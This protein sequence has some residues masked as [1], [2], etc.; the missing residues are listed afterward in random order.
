MEY[1]N[2]TVNFDDDKPTELHE[3]IS[4]LNGIKLQM[5]KEMKVDEEYDGMSLTDLILDVSKFKENNKDSDIDQVTDTLKASAQYW[6]PYQSY[7]QGL[8]AKHVFDQ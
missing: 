5:L 6:T 1:K 7:H 2:L 3:E 8:G 4:L